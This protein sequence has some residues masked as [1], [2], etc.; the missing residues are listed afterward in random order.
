MEC[1]EGKTRRGN[2]TAAQ[3]FWLLKSPK[4]LFDLF[5]SFQDLQVLYTSSQV[6][7][8]LFYSLVSLS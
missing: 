8:S 1:M 3:I 7:R 5:S 6:I 2:K 4:S